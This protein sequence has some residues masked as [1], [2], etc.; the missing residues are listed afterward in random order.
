MSVRLTDL[1]MKDKA[2]TPSEASYAVVIA[3]VSQMIA[4]VNRRSG[5]LEEAGEIYWISTS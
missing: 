1:A 3:P 2:T 5:H 4:V